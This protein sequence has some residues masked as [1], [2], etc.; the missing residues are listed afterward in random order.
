MAVGTSTAIA[1]GAGALAVGA[2]GVAIGAAASK[3]KK[4]QNVLPSGQ[5]NNQSQAAK[6][7]A[8]ARLNKTSGGSA[9]Q[10]L[11]QG[12]FRSKRQIFGN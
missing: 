10:E 8:A 1:I 6:Q 9:G 2:T 3:S 4:R 5:A 11:Q 12:D 7:A